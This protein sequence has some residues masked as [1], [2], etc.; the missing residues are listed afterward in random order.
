MSNHLRAAVRAANMSA[1]A[2]ATR[3][4]AGAMS[5]VAG[6]AALAASG[7][8][9][10]EEVVVTG[11][12][13]SLQQSIGMKRDNDALLD[14]I[15]AEDIGKFPDKNVA[16][17]L[18]R[19]PGITV[20]RQF[21]EGAAVSVRG[22]GN[23]LTLTT[24]NGQNVA[25][26]GWFAFQPARRSFNYELLPSELVGN[27]EVYKS[28]QADLLE[29]GVGGT[30]V[31]NTRKPLD[32]DAF[33]LFGSIE[34]QHQE[35]SGETDP[36]YS[37]LISW[38]NASETFGAL[39][40]AVSGERS[41]QRQGNEAFWEWGAGING[42]IQSRERT[43]ITYALQWRP[44]ENFEAVL[45]YVGLELG[46]DNTNYAMWLTQKNTSWSGIATPE[47]CLL[48]TTPVCGPLNVAF[49]QMRPREATMESDTFDLALAWRGEGFAIEFQVGNTDASG[50]TDF[51][52]VAD[53]EHTTG[54]TPLPDGT[55]DFRG[56]SLTWDLGDFDLATHDPGSIRMGQ[57][58]GFN[59]T[60]KTDEEFYW[61]L[62]AE[63]DVD[64]GPIY[65][66]K[67]GYRF[68]DHNSVSR[69]FWFDQAEDFNPVIQTS[70]LLDGTIDVG[71]GGYEIQKFS[72]EGIKAW[73]KA[74][75]TGQTEQLGNYQE[76]DEQNTAL[77][78]MAKFSEGAFRGNAGLRYVTTEA[79]SIYYLPDAAGEFQQ[80]SM[81][82]DYDELLPS[83][84]LAMELS[85]NWL[86]RFSAARVMTRPQYVDMYVNPQIT[87]A[88]DEASNNQF[89]IVGNVGLLPYIANQ[90]D[91]GL[92][93]Y[94]N[95]ASLLSFTLF[96]KD[97]KNFVTFTNTVVAHDA[98]P[99]PMPLD[100]DEQPFGWTVQEKNNGKAAEISGYEIIYQQDFGNGLG[101]V[102]NYT[103][104]DTT[105]DADTFPDG[106]TELDDSS[107]NVFNITGYFE[108]DLFHAR[109]SYNWRSEYMIREVGAYGARLHDDFGTLDFASSWYVTDNITIDFDIIN[110]T[111]EEVEQFGNNA[112]PTQGGR[113]RGFPLYFYET[114]R[115][116]VLG[117]SARF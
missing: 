54:G 64:I 109:L 76:I 113:T 71:V 95:D 5:A 50:G 90:Y 10:L 107:E 30:V 59:S 86:A 85:E 21:G 92:E 6:V 103:Y 49:W 34:G 83:F 87:G 102:G 116:F 63:F 53:V 17:S 81:D 112:M 25:S 78:A 110:L 39:L 26:T 93:W 98:V 69:N 84:N 11:Y 101:V 55:Y 56:G 19:V 22:V 73:A 43:G 40:S 57:D 91:I 16:E 2:G 52:M 114:P 115:R 36:L 51:E 61:Q 35:D 38:K 106:N 48:G 72:S 94:F 33:T 66:V 89:W 3:A 20:Q 88:N 28:S 111:E 14:A 18:Q 75:I 80:T 37:G 62:D 31:V 32:L 24:L 105:A 13:S 47:E 97:V 58:G 29:G 27:V 60:P 67:G 7:G 12:R 41:L 96:S 8:V 70:Q 42:F 1:A 117:V 23:D 4:A 46:A 82:A 108:N 44:N 104:T 65:A 100:A 99:A 15:T 68:A 77:Y 9:T 74:S 79:E 45:N